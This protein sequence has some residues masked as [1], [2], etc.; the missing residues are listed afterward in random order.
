[1]TG[2]LST[3]STDLKNYKKSVPAESDTTQ[4]EFLFYDWGA[5]SY[6]NL[7]N[8]ALPAKVAIAGFWLAEGQKNLRTSFQKFG[9][10]FPESIQNWQTP[11]LPIPKFPYPMGFIRGDLDIHIPSQGKQ[12]IEILSIGC[13]TCHGGHAFDKNGNPDFKTAILGFPN[14]SINLEGFT[15]SIYT[16]LKKISTD[17]ATLITTVKK[18]YP[19]ISAVE[20]FTLRKNFKATST[21]IQKLVKNVGAGLPFFNGGPGYTNGLAA[22]LIQFGILKSDSFHGDVRGFTSIPDLSN[23][24]FRTSLLYDGSYKLPRLPGFAPMFKRDAT[25]EHLFALADI[26]TFFTIPTMGVDP[27]TALKQI[28][29]GQKISKF[30]YRY[31]APAFP[32]ERQFEQAKIGETIYQTN[33]LQ[34]HGQFDT[35]KSTSKDPLEMV[36]YPNRLVLQDKIGTDPHRIKPINPYMIRVLKNSPMGTYVEAVISKG[37]ISPILTGIWASAP[38]LHNASVPSLWALMNPEQRPKRFLIGGHRIDFKTLGMDLVRPAN[39]DDVWSYPEN[40][41]PWMKPEIYDTSSSGRSNAGHEDEFK[42][43][44]QTDKVNLIEYLKYL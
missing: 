8:S 31:R 17:E 14:T 36:W 28:P 38:Y 1:M 44:S 33:C 2:C 27:V 32:G 43:L 37:Y 10:I 34:C 6:S 42:G 13:A 12:R 24:Q 5:L 15:K 4:A 22:I 29:V 9:F 35:L 16:G 11:N 23:R 40:Y 30:L 26:Y 18:L 3:E 25:P 7:Q 39:V 21:R 20:E 19:D 41:Q